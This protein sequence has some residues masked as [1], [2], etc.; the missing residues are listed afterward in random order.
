MTA[1]REAARRVLETA[2]AF[3]GCARE[4]IDAI[5]RPAVAVAFARGDVVYRRGEAGSSLMV[6]V[7][8]SLKVSN[9]TAEGRDVV[10]GFV[11]AGGLIGEVAA[12]DGRERTATVVALE[13]TEALIIHR[14]DLMAVLEARPQ[15]ALAVMT[16]LCARLRETNRL[17]E[18]LSLDAMARVA[19]CLLR[20][21]GQHGV[22][23]K[24]GLAID[25]KLTQRDLGGHLGLTRE[26]VSRT[27][28]ELRQAGAIELAGAAIVILDREALE[29]LV[30]A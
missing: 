26:T 17:L 14:R 1:D 30:A 11:R 2:S 21:A 16:G 27:L 7:A 25:L 23:S 6:V 3:A 13:P 29:R 19:D 4:V 18:S 10:L 15:A 22:P 9:V 12:L 28:S 5:L 8:G 20:L 24:E